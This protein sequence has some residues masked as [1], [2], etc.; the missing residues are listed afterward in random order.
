MDYG[1][2][3]VVSSRFG[4][5]FRSNCAKC[6]LVAA[7]V[8]AEFD[9]ALTKAVQANPGLR[10]TIDVERLVVAA[11]DAGIE[12]PFPLDPATQHRLLNGLDDIG[13]TLLR[14]SDIEAYE[15]RRLPWMPAATMAESAD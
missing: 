10:V 5:I 2:K 8:E 9:A 14:R 6:G 7:Q 13:I 3:A 15:R 12:S 1:F 4:D 11:P